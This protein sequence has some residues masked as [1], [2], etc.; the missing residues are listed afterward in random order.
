M[1]VL[2]ERGGLLMRVN[3][4]G[5]GEYFGEASACSVPCV[6]ATVKKDGQSL[7]SSPASSLCQLQALPM[8]LLPASFSLPVN[9]PCAVCFVSLAYLSAGNDYF[10]AKADAEKG[11]LHPLCFLHAIS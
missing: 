2:E 1:Q 4:R 7:S 6:A 10:S 8:L 5:P 9:F 11:S 3:T